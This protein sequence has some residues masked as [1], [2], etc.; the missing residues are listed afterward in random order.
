MGDE[1]LVG[2]INIAKDVSVASGVGG[3]DR[4]VARVL[5]AMDPAAPIRLKDFR[6]TLPGQGTLIAAF[7]QDSNA[8]SLFNSVVS[9]GL[10]AFWM[11]MQSNVEQDDLREM[12]RLEKFR[13]MLKQTNLGMGMERLIYELNPHLPCLSP[14]LERDYVPDIGH[15]LPALDRLAEQSGGKLD[16]LIDREIAAFISRHF[17]RPISGDLKHMED[18]DDPHQAKLA[19][20]HIL[21][22]L[23]DSIAKDESFPFLCGAMEHFLDAV[24]DRYYSHTRRKVIRANIK[25]AAKSGKIQTVLS[26]IDNNTL[27]KEDFNGFDAAKLSYA[28]S[29]FETI[30]TKRDIKNRKQLAANIGG[31]IAT[32]LA[33]LASVSII[34]ISVVVWKL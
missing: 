14:L 7:A 24:V 3:V 1:E 20:V 33:G 17:K 32:A 16:R 18:L 2:K 27:L 30:K 5:I 19:E 15:L 25:K 26:M 13:N 23:Q 11:E 8:R 31:E 28:R 34:V 21:A 29:I 6:A 12:Q 10:V 9:M 22:S 4:L